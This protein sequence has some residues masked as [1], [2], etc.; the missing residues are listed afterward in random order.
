MLK[1]S[2]VYFRSLATRLAERSEFLAPINKNADSPINVFGGQVRGIGLRRTCFIEQFVVR[3]A[4][5]ILFRSDDCCVFLGRDRS[6]A[7]AADFGPCSFTR[8]GHGSQPR[9]TAKL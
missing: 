5:E 3:A 7:L 6:F 9:S 1:G 2:K 8:M 4:F